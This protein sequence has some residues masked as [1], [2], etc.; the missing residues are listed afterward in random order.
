MI[1]LNNTPV[2]GRIPCIGKAAHGWLTHNQ[3]GKVLAVVNHATYLLTEQG[4]L[5]WLVTPE[6][7]LH[8]RCIQVPAW[9]PRPAIDSLYTIQGG[10]I[11][12]DSGTKLDFRPS[13]IWETPILSHS[14][15][16]DI[17][18]IP[19]RLFAV[20]ESFLE[21]N[22]PVGIG[23][24]IRAVLQIAINPDVPVCLLSEDPIIR[25]TWQYIERVVRACLSHDLC[26]VLPS[27]E[28][29]IGLGEGL[30]PSGDDFLGGLFFARFLL[31][32]SYPQ[33]HYLEFDPLPEWMHAVQFRT[34]LISYTLL[35]DH[36]N[37]HALEPLNKFGLAIFTN[38]SVEST[39]LA[40][41]D[42][43]KIGHTTG[44]SLLTGFLVGMLLVSP[45]PPSMPH[46]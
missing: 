24:C 32:S 28:N 34:N 42:L 35:S 43:I 16:I 10:S 13:I 45:N 22:T 41:A 19:E 23:S 46:S 27:S 40:A 26:A 3:R 7:P 4:E 18:L 17:K 33:L 38:R 44:W 31:S 15:A 2:N 12:F 21:R 20:Y 8:R 39:C 30:T 9:L 5:V 36:V 25:N 6:D 1:S 29:L 14:E 11:E 37:G